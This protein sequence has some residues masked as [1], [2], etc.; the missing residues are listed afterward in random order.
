MHCVLC[1]RINLGKK[2]L[3]FIE[4]YLIQCP[5]LR[6]SYIGGYCIHVLVTCSITH[7]HTH[8]QAG[9]KLLQEGMEE[10]KSLLTFDLRL[11]EINQESEYCINKIIKDNQDRK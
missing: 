3:S 5:Y 2:V 4:R 6:V 1:T 11:T 8:T 9:G 10:N 7:K